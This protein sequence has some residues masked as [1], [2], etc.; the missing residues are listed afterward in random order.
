MASL[1]ALHLLGHHVEEFLAVLSLVHVHKVDNDNTSHIPESQLAGDFLGALNIDLQGGIFLT[2]A[3][4]YV[5]AAVDIDDMHGLRV[6]NIE[7]N[8]RADGDN[9]PES[10]ADVA[11]DAELLENGRLHLVVLH[12]VLLAWLY[13]LEEL[14]HIVVKVEIVDIDGSEVVG[15]HVAQQ[16]RGGAEFGVDLGRGV[17][18]FQL[19]CHLAPGIHEAAQ[20]GVEFGH[21]AAFRHRT[22]D[23]AEV[24]RA[25]ALHQPAQA[26]A[27][28]I[29]FDFLRD[30]DFI[31]ERGE[32][33]VA[34]GD[35][36]VTRHLG[37]FCGDGF[38]G[39]LH[40][41]RLT[42]FEHV[43]HV[44]HLLKDRL[45]LEVFESDSIAVAVHG[46][47]E[48]FVHRAVVGTQVEVVHETLLV[49]PE[50]DESGI[51]SLHDFLHLAEENVAHDKLSCRHLLVEFHQAL[52][53]QQGYLHSFSIRCYY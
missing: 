15:Q 22:D 31:T 28:F 44:A 52:V 2:C 42:H 27:F 20:V 29:L 3:G 36:D 17:D 39:D 1:V 16:C 19:L 33:Q 26:V 14:A 18:T 7:V 24:L 30:G 45:Y 5:V 43:A 13:A 41:H 40:Q 53:L 10:A 47:A 23:Y 11:R 38:L 37:A 9:L 25:Y 46:K 35:G 51:E 32:Y 49:A 48:V 8:A 34:A 21:S 12:N 50:I 6:L 4:L